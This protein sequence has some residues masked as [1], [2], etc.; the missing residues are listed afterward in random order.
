ML[1]GVNTEL[2]FVQMSF[3]EAAIAAPPTTHANVVSAGIVRAVT[4]DGVRRFSAN[5][6]GKGSVVHFFRTLRVP[7]GEGG[8]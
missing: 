1:Q 6:A 4:T 3:A 5:R 2:V 8:S 7:L